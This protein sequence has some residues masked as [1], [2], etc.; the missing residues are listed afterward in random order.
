MSALTIAVGQLTVKIGHRQAILISKII[1]QKGGPE[2]RGKY[3]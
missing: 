1:L 2:K 3:G